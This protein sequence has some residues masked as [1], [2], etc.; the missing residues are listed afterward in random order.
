[1]SSQAVIKFPSQILGKLLKLP[2]SCHRIQTHYGRGIGV[3]KGKV[4]V[5]LILLLKKL[6]PRMQGCFRILRTTTFA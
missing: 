1:M 3:L 4:D 2:S 6:L 5:K